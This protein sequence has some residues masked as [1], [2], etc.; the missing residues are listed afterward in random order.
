MLTFRKY[1]ELYK[2]KTEDVINKR[3]RYLEKNKVFTKQIEQEEVWNT[4]KKFFRLYRFLSL[5]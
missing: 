1:D 3:I 4:F 2:T 5:E